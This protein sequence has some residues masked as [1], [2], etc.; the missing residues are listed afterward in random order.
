MSARRTTTGDKRLR[1][2][3]SQRTMMSEAIHINGLGIVQTGFGLHCQEIACG[4]GHLKRLHRTLTGEE[5]IVPDVHFER[6][7]RD[8]KK[9]R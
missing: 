3:T 6:R 8:A 7:K 1:Q 9:S 5:P 2:V 4:K